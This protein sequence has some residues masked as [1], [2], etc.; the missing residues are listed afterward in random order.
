MKARSLQEFNER[1]FK[2]KRG[3]KWFDTKGVMKLNENLNAEIK[4]VT[5]MV[6]DHYNAF[7]VRIVNKN[8]GEITNHRFK[9]ESYLKSRIDN[10]SDCRNQEFEVVKYVSCDWYIAI[11][12][13]KE[14]KAMV[15]TIFDF[16]NMYK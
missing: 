4:L 8:D 10:R 2:G 12:D 13:E 11:P 15:K 14:I 3:L 9:F 6:H 1:F 16:I 5:G 7:T